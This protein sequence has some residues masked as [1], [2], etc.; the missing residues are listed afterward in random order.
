MHPI[1][2]TFILIVMSLNKKQG[3]LWMKRELPEWSVLIENVLKWREEKDNP[4]KDNENFLKTK[5]YSQ[6]AQAQHLL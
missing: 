4:E 3:A 1:Q 5:Q 6:S 2:I